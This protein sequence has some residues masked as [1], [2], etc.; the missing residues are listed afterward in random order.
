MHLPL[1]RRGA[2]LGLAA[3]LAAGRHQAAL[4]NAPGEARF[5]V[6]VLRGALDGLAAAAPYSDPAFATLRGPLALAEPGK[7]GGYLDLGGRFGL[8]PAMP[9]THALFQANQAALVHAVAGNWRTRSHFDGQDFLESGADKRLAAGWLNRAV[10]ALWPD[11]ARAGQAE[12]ARKALASGVTVPLLLRGPAR[13]Q[14]YVPRTLPGPSAEAMARLATLYARD[15]LLGPV[16]ADATAGRRFAETAMGSAPPPAAQGERAGFVELMRATGAL[17]AE[18]RG[19]R[20]A[21]AELN[22][23][24]THANQAARLAPLLGTLDAG[25]AALRG[26]LGPAWRN[27][28]VLAMTEFGRSVRANG[29]GGTDHGTAGVAFVLGGAVAGGRSFGDWPGL[30]DL[31]EGRD[32]A[33]TTDLRALAKGL[34]AGHLRMGDAALAQVFPDSAGVAAMRGVV[35]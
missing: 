31:H 35:G 4:A 10:L 30:A 11:Q 33:P 8:H 3:T 16:F 1:S 6:L 12:A 15:P 32:L 20:I 18:P 34:L 13:A 27:T 25:V 2:I 17:L 29:T 26:A 23:F 19:P 22:G 28:C 21:A 5:V 24:D 9:E 7:D 14:N